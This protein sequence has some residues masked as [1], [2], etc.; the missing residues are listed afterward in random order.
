[1]VSDTRVRSVLFVPDR[2]MDHRIWS[3]IPDRIRSQADT[4]HFDQHHEMPWTETDNK[5]L[6]SARSL[7]RGTFDV[8]AAAGQ[9]DRLAFALAEAGLAHS[10]VLFQ[11][12]IPASAIP[13]GVRP[14]IS[15][16]DMDRI[17]EDA[18]NA[19]NPLADAI[20]D[21]DIS[22]RRDAM[23]NFVRNYAGVSLQPRELEL[24]IGMAGDHAEELFG[25]VRTFQAADAEGRAPEEPWAARPWLEHFASVTVPIALIVPIRAMPI[26]EGMV[27]G[28]DIEVVTAE[29]MAGLAS[30][31]DRARGADTILRM[32]NQI[33]YG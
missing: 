10:L 19:Y 12:F 32:L 15:G 14:D 13:D 4:I 26:A 30:E 28:R 24:A 11:P 21:P 20:R 22:R 18:A 3:D 2:F 25:A 31:D 6:G 23:L 17:F 29:G 9:A 27:A 16:L 8:V 5:F 1:M 33:R 7:A